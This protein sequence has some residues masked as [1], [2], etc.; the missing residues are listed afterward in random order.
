MVIEI[1]LF[2]KKLKIGF[3]KRWPVI[4]F[5][6]FFFLIKD[7]NAYF[8]LLFKLFITKDD[9]FVFKD[10]LKILDKLWWKYHQNILF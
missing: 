10:I 7:K 6:G 4:R 9:I 1:Q 2:K 8:C 5:Y 3:D